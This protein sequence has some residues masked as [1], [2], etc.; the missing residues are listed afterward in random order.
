MEELQP[1]YEMAWK[2]LQ[3]LKTEPGD[4]LEFGVSEGTSMA[5]MHR[6]TTKLNLKT[7]RLIG[8]DSFEGMPE[9][10]AVEDAGTWK[11]GQFA[12]P[13]E[14]T[15][16]FLDKEGVD[17]KR[18]FLIKGWFEDT[19][20]EQTTKQYDIRKASIIMIDCD[21]YSAS[22][23]A[24]NYS[25]PMIKDYAVIVFDDW[26]DDKSFGEYKAYDEFL[27]ENKFL[28]S[29]EIGTYNPAGKLFRITNTNTVKST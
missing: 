15:K 13:I 8:F 17:W 27:N 6:V 21:I 2:H 4:Y 7:V 5:C 12:N 25:L 24:L 19:C 11:P 10:A 20:N 22:K 14:D 28:K 26:H 1:K 23:V 29:V 16:A 18:T 3:E 9:S